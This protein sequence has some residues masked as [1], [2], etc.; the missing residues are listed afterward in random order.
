MSSTCKPNPEAIG[1]WL[2]GSLKRLL[3]IKKE[4]ISFQRSNSKLDNSEDLTTRF[5]GGLNAN[6]FFY[7]TNYTTTSQS[8][9][10]V[11]QI[12][13]DT[14]LIPELRWSTARYSPR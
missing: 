14:F 12:R 6:T 1:N 2:V 7:F 11:N 3:Q 13:N 10:L 9:I 4:K 5:R 8:F